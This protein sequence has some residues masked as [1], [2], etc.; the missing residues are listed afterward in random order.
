[1]NSNHVSIDSLIL[2][3]SVCRFYGIRLFLNESGECPA[4]VITKYTAPTANQTPMD[5]EYPPRV[6]QLQQRLQAF[7]DE[8]VLPNELRFT[9]HMAS[10][11]N[12]WR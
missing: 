5:F 12:P 7:M 6:E 4:I 8:H 1:M 2:H 3:Y 11:D 10:T 9:E